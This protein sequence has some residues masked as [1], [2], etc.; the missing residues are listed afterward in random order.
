MITLLGLSLLGAGVVGIFLASL[1]QD[2]GM[3]LQSGSKKRDE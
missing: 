3:G 1:S 2:I